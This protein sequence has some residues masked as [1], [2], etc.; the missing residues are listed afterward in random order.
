MH[1]QEH[2]AGEAPMLGETDLTKPPSEVLSVYDNQRLS[3]SYRYRSVARLFEHNN[4][5]QRP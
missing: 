1:L 2:L 5:S 3:Y 4:Y